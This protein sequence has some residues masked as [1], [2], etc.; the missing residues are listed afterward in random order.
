MDIQKSREHRVY[1]E[2]Y[3]EDKRKDILEHQRKYAKIALRKLLNHCI[4]PE[5]E[6]FVPEQIK[7]MT[8]NLM[9]IVMTFEREALETFNDLP[10]EDRARLTA[11]YLNK[12]WS[13]TIDN[14]GYFLGKGSPLSGKPETD[15][16]GVHV[17]MHQNV[18]YP[19][20]VY[21]KTEADAKKAV[22]ILGERLLPLFE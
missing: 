9:N 15:I 8:R 5:E 3:I 22:K 7:F 14:T 6:V 19:G 16:K 13:K 4:H 11:D 18:K 1:T 10:E 17:A 2:E 21:F 12:G 20:I